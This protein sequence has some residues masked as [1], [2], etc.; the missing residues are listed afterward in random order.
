M[1]IE[2]IGVIGAG[3]MGNG[4]A[5]CFAVAGFAV[6][7]QDLSAAALERGRA[8]IETSL[9]RQVKKGALTEAEAADALS[10]I[11]TATE[12]TAM[13][14][15]D[16]VVEAIVERLEVKT[17]VLKQLDAICGAQTILASNTS[18]I[19]LTQIAAASAHPGRVIGMHFF[20]PVAM[21][22]LIEIIRA[23]Q[24]T[25]EVAQAVTEVARAIGKSPHASSDSYGFVVNRLLVPFINEAI[26]CVHEGVA[27][28]QDV[29]AM[30]KLGANHPMGP[31]ALG[32]LIGLDVVLNIMETLCQGFDDPKYRPSPLLKQ[33]VHAGW[34]G[35]K[36]GKG[37]FDYPG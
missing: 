2:K 23:L 6:V 3:T 4:I 27:T 34:L 1:K 35:R 37:F 10:R 28:P 32:D 8:A 17:Q 20:N 16:L 7:M 13:A 33:M 30:M 31:L 19:S 14:D 11:T 36:T 21:M 9:A 29:D 5:Q 15:R 26:N 24:T 25:D 22:Q 18:S 12:L